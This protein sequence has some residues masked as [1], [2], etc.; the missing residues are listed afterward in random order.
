MIAVKESGEL[1]FALP[2][3][4]DEQVLELELEEGA[5]VVWPGRASSLLALLGARELL[6]CSMLIFISK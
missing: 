1:E 2:V 4:D 5:K 3:E 6:N